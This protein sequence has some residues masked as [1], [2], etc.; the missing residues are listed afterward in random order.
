MTHI[1]RV[2][3]V[4]VLFVSGCTPAPMII[5]HGSYDFDTY[6][7][8]DAHFDDA[9][10]ALMVV[11][12]TFPLEAVDR[13]NGRVWTE[14]M[15]A[16]AALHLTRQPISE[17]EDSLG[18]RFGMV[19][20]ELAPGVPYIVWLHSGG[21]AEKSGARYRDIIVEVNGADPNDIEDMRAFIGDAD[22][23]QLTVIRGEA[24]HLKE[25]TIPASDPSATFTYVPF[26]SRYR[27]A[28]HLSPADGD[29]TTVHIYNE[30]EVDFGAFS[31]SDRS[32]LQRVE[33]STIK[34]WLLMQELEAELG[35]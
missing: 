11:L 33:S 22:T 2:A 6:K 14:W 4:A 31:D 24:N 13:D 10:D 8:L 20:V 27:L 15:D 19:V 3:I 17:P 18:L 9:W 29:R 21:P 16:D 7:T 32:R 1:N 34:E 5:E 28:F 12:E 23:L 25:L 30:E 26:P 35:L